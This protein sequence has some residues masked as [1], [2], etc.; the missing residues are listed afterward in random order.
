MKR[1]LY[2]ILDLLTVAFLVGAYV[3]QYFTKRK[4]G[5]LRSMNYQNMQFQQHTSYGILKYITV[6]AALILVV[7]IIFGY[8]KK[9][10]KMGILNLVMIIIMVV[11]TIVYLGITAFLSTES[12]TSYYLVMPLTGAAVLMQIIRNGI[13]VGT[14][15]NEK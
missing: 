4:L 1:L 8:R 5:M 7:L 15:K 6:I 12:L 14:K 9:K 10:E 3:I 2:I 11:L 13:A